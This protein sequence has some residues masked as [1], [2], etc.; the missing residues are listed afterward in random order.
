[1]TENTNAPFMRRI[2]TFMR[3]SSP[4]TTSQKQGMAD[5][6]PRFLLP[7]SREDFNATEVFGREA[8]LTVE[9]GFGMG[10]SLAEMAE[11]AP[12]RNFVGIEIH[13]PGVAQL[14]F[15]LG[16]RNIP[17]VRIMDEDALELLEARFADGSI[18][19]VQLYF[20]DPWPKARHHKRRFVNA[21]N[22]ALIRRKLKPG[23]LFHMATDWEN[24]AE[25]MLEHMEAAPGFE[26][27]AGQGQYSPRPDFRPLTKFEKRGHKLGHGV[28]DLIYRAI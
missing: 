23:G 2:Q 24:Y 14:C 27:A 15:E 20:P 17:N 16:T 7:R 5:F 6:A 11:A 28:W 12:E 18:D 25:W 10:Y 13:E 26:N 3:R 1:M 9:I 4:F 19:I 21:T 8:P 22:A